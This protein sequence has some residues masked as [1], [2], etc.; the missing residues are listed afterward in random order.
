MLHSGVALPGKL[1]GR[2]VGNTTGQGPEQ[3]TGSPNLCSRQLPAE[4]VST[5]KGP[6]SQSSPLLL[7]VS[8]KAF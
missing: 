7:R 3:E 5:G 8:T 1:G 2:E 6:L 4:E